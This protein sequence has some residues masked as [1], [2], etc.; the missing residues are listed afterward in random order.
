[1]SV[2]IFGNGPMPNEPEFAVTAP[3]SR[4]WQIVR[5]VAEGLSSS[6]ALTEDIVVLSLDEVPRPS[7]TGS[8]IVTE[9]TASGRKIPVEYRPLPYEQFK[10]LGVERSPAIDLPPS[11]RA[12]IG[13]GSVQP[14][15]TAAGFARLRSLPL[16]IDVF[17]DPICET[18]SQLELTTAADPSA[19]DT[20]LVH[21]WK[22]MLDALLD[23]DQFYALSRRQRHALQ[24]QLGCAGRLNQ[25][26]SSASIAHYLPYAVFEDDTTL[27]ESTP[28]SPGDH[29]TIMWCGSFN[30][31]MDVPT[32]TRG[33]TDALKGDPNLRLLVV[34][35]KI[36]SYNEISYGQFLEGIKSAGVEGA[37]TLMDWQPLASMQQLYTRCDLGISIDRYTYE[38]EL[39]SRTRLVNFLAAGIPVASTVVTELSEEL[40]A[41]EMLMPFEMGNADSL[42][43][44]LL[45]AA[46]GNP[47]A[48]N[49]GANCRNYILQHF[50]GRN[51]GE[52]LRKWLAYP[53]KAP[54]LIADLSQ[55]T[56]ALT[57]HWRKL[58]ESLGV[59]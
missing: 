15:S 17:G 5:T 13:T 20:R 51:W 21:V 37:V 47:V 10:Q 27:T 42:T 44:T 29:Y 43:R 34:G 19:A 36:A 48:R 59:Y 40:Q 1:M 50:N 22:L 45:S 41:A 16:W 32:L 4:T 7:T 57:P 46:A 18:Q 12:V 35:G 24:G 52:E 26:T 55:N 14:Y 11:I 25:F 2:I 28:P 49:K 30:T 9:V 58:R 33:I 8:A 23:G 6:G 56:N 39:G 38:A 31:W 3:G 53:T 54:D